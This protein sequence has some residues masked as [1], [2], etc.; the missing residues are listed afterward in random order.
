MFDTVFVNHLWNW[1]ESPLVRFVARIFSWLRKLTR[2]GSWGH[3]RVCLRHKP[4]VKFVACLWLTPRNVVEN[5]GKLIDFCEDSKPCLTSFQ[6]M[7]IIQVV[8][9]ILKRVSISRHS[10]VL[11]RF[12]HNIVGCLRGTHSSLTCSFCTTSGSKPNHW[13]PLR[14]YPVFLPISCKLDIKWKAGEEI[15]LEID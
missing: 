6:R 15:I 4:P 13:W 1:S 7:Y 14:L 3:R 10:N 11:A 5:Y 12:S 9:V 2:C 8:E